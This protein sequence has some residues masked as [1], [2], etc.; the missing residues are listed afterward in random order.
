MLVTS[1]KQSPPYALQQVLYTMRPLREFVLVLEVVFSF[2]S[3][4]WF[5]MYEMF[6]YPVA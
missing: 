1:A 6:E 3:D 2:Q 4:L 5:S